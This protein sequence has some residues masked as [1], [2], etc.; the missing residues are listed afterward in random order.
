MSHPLA[1]SPG[2]ARPDPSSS[3]QEEG[4]PRNYAGEPWVQGS[5]LPAD[6]C[7]TAHAMVL[8]PQ[9]NERLLQ[10]SNLSKS[11]EALQ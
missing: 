5:A 3:C 10:S 2:G 6:P 11:Q 1:P 8:G 4:R 9:K 7:R